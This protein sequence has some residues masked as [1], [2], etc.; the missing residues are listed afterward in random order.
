MS[1]LG[2]GWVQLAVVTVLAAT[3]PAAATGTEQPKVPPAGSGALRGIDLAGLSDSERGAFWRLLRKY[4]S[5]CG[6]AESL[7]S[8]LRSDERCRRSVFAGRYIVRLLKSGLLESEVEER[9]EARFG[10]QPHDEIDL[11]ES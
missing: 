6:K 10:P 5:V 2:R 1:L 8:S 9:Y 4:P 11:K 3:R 7:E